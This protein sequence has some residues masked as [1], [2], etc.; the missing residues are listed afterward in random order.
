MILAFSKTMVIEAKTVKTLFED[1]INKGIKL[2]TI[3]EDKSKRWKKGMKIHFA[4]GVRTAYYKNFKMGECKSTQTIKINDN[5]VFVDGKKIEQH[6]LQYL[7]YNDGF[8]T[9]EQ[10][11]GYFKP[12]IPFEGTLI[13]WTSLKYDPETKYKNPDLEK[14]LESI[15]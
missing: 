13:H 3:R 4:N 14:P 5:E 12:Y 6:T 8:D 9:L 11:W 1:K 2:H 15:S 7:I 10:F